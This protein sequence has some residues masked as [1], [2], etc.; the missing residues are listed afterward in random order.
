MYSVVEEYHC[1]NVY[2]IPGRLQF[3]INE[4]VLWNRILGRKY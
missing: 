1:Q 3:V 4:I 2:P